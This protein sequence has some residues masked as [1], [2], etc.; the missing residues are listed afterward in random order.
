METETAQISELKTTVA[1]LK[2]EV[3]SL[4]SRVLFPEHLDRIIGP[5]REEQ[6]RQ[7]VQLQ[8][9][10]DAMATLTLQTTKNAEL[11]EDI[12]EERHQA[13]L[14]A[15]AAELAQAKEAMAW[16]RIT[17]YVIPFFTLIG[18]GGVAY[19]ALHAIVY[20]MANPK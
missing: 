4:K 8:R 7:G 17:K 11:V 10:G 3:E 19:A 12:L 20:F 13:A 2:V 1:V 16:N 18:G 9:I 14:N 6:Q 15:A 5:M